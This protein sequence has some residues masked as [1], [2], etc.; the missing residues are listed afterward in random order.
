MLTSGTN[1]VQVGILKGYSEII[2]LGCD[3]NYTEVINGAEIIDNKGKIVMKEN[4]NKNPNYWF[5]EY[6][7]KGDEFN[8]PNTNG[9]QLP[10]WN[11]LYET[12]KCLK[13]NVKI[14]NVND[15]SKIE[16]FDK[17]LIDEYFNNYNK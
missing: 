3:C 4:I 9:C 5:D 17:I 12:I 2:L 10:A 1:S 11:R 8:V 7:Q 15:N 13:L 6:Q 16:C 14:L